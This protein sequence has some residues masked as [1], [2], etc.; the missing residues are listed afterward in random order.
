MDASSAAAGSDHHGVPEIRIAPAPLR[1]LPRSMRLEV[2]NHELEELLY[3]EQGDTMAATV[4]HHQLRARDGFMKASCVKHRN[5]EVA[6][7]G[8]DQRRRDD[9]LPVFAVIKASGDDL[10][11]TQRLDGFVSLEL[12]CQ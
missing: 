9:A 4:H 10:S 8:D 12:P 7:T 5:G 3:S 2:V 1:R 11:G 6:R